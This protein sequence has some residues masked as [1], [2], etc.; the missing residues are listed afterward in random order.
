MHLQ[1][2]VQIANPA[3]CRLNFPQERFPLTYRPHNLC[4]TQAGLTTEELE[5]MEFLERENRELRRAN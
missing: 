1:P 5:G 3:I 2:R 4:D